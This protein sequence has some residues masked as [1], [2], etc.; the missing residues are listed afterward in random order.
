MLLLQA[1][2]QPLPLYPAASVR[3]RFSAAHG[4]VEEAPGA[5]GESPLAGPATRPDRLD[6]QTR[7]AGGPA[8]ELGQ[9]AI[10]VSRDP[11]PDRRHSS[12]PA[13][14]EVPRRDLSALVATYA[15]GPTPWAICGE[16]GRGGCGRGI[17]GAPS[18][19]EGGPILHLPGRLPFG[20][21]GTGD[22]GGP[23]EE[24]SR[25]RQARAA[26]LWDAALRYRGHSGD[27]EEGASQRGDPQALG[28]QGV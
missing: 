11:A 17:C 26:V 6:R 27:P 18:R 28:G 9:R 24:R 7:H 16:A 2:L 1:L 14:G 12:R 20:G 3:D 4:R 22:G 25:G 5:G 13:V 8:R 10:V 21:S 19:C 15:R 23:G